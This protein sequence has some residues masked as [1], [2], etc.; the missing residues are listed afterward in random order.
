[1]KT[2]LDPDF[3]TEETPLRQIGHLDQ[4]AYLQLW[5]SLL[6]QHLMEKENQIGNAFTD[7]DGFRI[8]FYAT[9]GE[10]RNQF[11]AHLNKGFEVTTYSSI[12]RLI[13]NTVDMA[14]LW[15]TY[16]TSVRY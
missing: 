5:S 3:H 15:Q 4:A 11:Q 8:H 9:I 7:P 13:D 1:M 12:Q 6:E 2:L 10:K 14:S 16:F